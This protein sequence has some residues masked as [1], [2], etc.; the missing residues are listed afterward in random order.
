MPGM[1]DQALVLELCTCTCRFHRLATFS[2]LV[3]AG[4]TAIVV[5][6]LTE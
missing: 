1:R 3:R 6:D 5:K 4:V 2:P